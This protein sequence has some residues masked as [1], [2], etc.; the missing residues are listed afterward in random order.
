MISASAGYSQQSLRI[1]TLTL[2]DTTGG[3]KLKNLTGG[4]ADAYVGWLE[5]LDSIYTPLINMG[6]GTYLT[7][8]SGG[9]RFGIGSEANVLSLGETEFNLWNFTLTVDSDGNITSVG[10][11]DIVSGDA[12]ISGDV[13][14][15]GSIDYGTAYSTPVAFTTAIDA[16]TG[17]LFTQTL[18]GS[19]STNI[20]NMTNGQI[21]TV[22]VN[23]GTGNDISF[24]ALGGETFW[25]IGGSP[26]VSSTGTDIYTFLKAGTNIYVSVVQDFQ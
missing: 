23:T 12:D 11:L 26:P 5:A 17:T 10:D 18:S 15:G 20:S 14:I 22:I 21:I 7:E 16:S 13:T 3:L 8:I 4:R 1:G 6:N 9:L 24:G 19:Q 25:W 2:K